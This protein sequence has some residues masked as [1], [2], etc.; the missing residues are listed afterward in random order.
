MVHLN[1]LTKAHRHIL[2]SVFKNVKK[3]N[4][5]N[6]TEIVS[7][8]MYFEKDQDSNKLKLIKNDSIS[9]END[10]IMAYKQLYK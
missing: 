10:D 1:M 2:M 8:K 4:V 7:V 9:F 3:L 6:D 5:T